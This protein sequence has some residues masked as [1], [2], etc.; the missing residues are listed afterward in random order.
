MD[1][2]NSA[3]VPAEIPVEE[4]IL[5]MN[6]NFIVNTKRQSVRYELSMYSGSEMEAT[7]TSPEYSTPEETAEDLVGF[8]AAVLLDAA[9]E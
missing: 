7:Q 4:T 8:L 5:T 2:Q 6:V 9:V 1:E 3:P